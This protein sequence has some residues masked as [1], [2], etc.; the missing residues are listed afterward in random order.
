MS[1][2]SWR[3]FWSSSLKSSAAQICYEPCSIAVAFSCLLSFFPVFHF[4]S[5]FLSFSLSLSFFFSFLFFFLPSFLSLFLSFFLSSFSAPRTGKICDMCTSVTNEKKKTIS[6]LC[7]TVQFQIA[8]LLRRVRLATYQKEVSSAFRSARRAPCAGVHRQSGLPSVAMAP[9]VIVELVIEIRFEKPYL[10]GPLLASASLSSAFYVPRRE[11]AQGFPAGSAFRIFRRAASFLLHFGALHHLQNPRNQREQP[12]FLRPRPLQ[13]L[14][15]LH[16]HRTKPLQQFE[17]L[18]FLCQRPL[19]RTAAQSPSRF[20]AFQSPR[21]AAFP[22]SPLQVAP[23]PRNVAPA[24]HV[25]P[26]AR[27]RVRASILPGPTKKSLLV[28]H[29]VS[30]CCLHHPSIA[31]ETKEYFFLPKF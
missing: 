3:L 22:P 29:R 25:S 21:T 19:P 30:D 7:Q 13:H 17:F 26:G 12:L 18:H 15:L 24:L 16:F 28:L 31:A 14:Q 8:K 2:P 9:S 6:H 11:P 5:L 23:S 20:E 1:L 10:R 4:L 27:T